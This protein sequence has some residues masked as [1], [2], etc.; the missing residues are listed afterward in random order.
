MVEAGWIPPTV[1]SRN[2]VQGQ[3]LAGEE[4]KLFATKATDFLGCSCFRSQA[5]LL[6]RAMSDVCDGY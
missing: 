2:N 6:S 1:G 5:T 3:K 4:T